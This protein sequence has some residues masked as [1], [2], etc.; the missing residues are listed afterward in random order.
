[1][2]L[3]AVEKS[4][5]VD[6]VVALLSQAMLDGTLNPGEA[7]R[8]A[9]LAQSLEVARSTVRE[10]LQVLASK[11]L[12][13]RSPNQGAVVRQL[14]I[15]EVEDIY[16]G[17]IV[18]ELE[19]ARA[20]QQCPDAALARLE[21]AFGAYERAARD[22]PSRAADAHVEFHAAMVAIIGSDRLVQAERSMM[23][24][25]QLAIASIDKSS[26]D[27]PNEVTKHRLLCRL[28]CERRIDEALRQLEADLEH[29]R[30]Y[31]LRCTRERAAERTP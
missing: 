11:G 3:R 14:G 6:R 17:R 21:E 12:I 26:D 18:L 2:D 22:G 31:L 15:A 19:A 23:Q 29:S 7:L 9:A 5:T 27:L 28:F 30:E 4:T 10:A 20:A 13:S 24:D 16:R 25:I 1:M 8:E